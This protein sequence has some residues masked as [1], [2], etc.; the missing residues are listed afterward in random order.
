MNSNE[1]KKS[2]RKYDPAFKEEVLKM[3]RNGRPVPQIAQS[4]GIGEN[5][6]YRW[7]ALHIKGSGKKG[8][9]G[10]EDTSVLHK[11]IRTL[12]IECEILKKALSIFSR[13]N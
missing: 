3:V 12:E 6:V 2:Y 7:K 5:L 10:V 9:P 1:K 8:M 4:L 13:Q 11:R